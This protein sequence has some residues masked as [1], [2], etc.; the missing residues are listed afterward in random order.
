MR[1][2]QLKGIYEFAESKEDEWVFDESYILT[3]QN[4]NEI[5]E[6]NVSFFFPTAKKKVYNR[7]EI[8]VAPICIVKVHSIGDVLF[9]FWISHTSVKLTQVAWIQW[10]MKLKMTSL[11]MTSVCLNYTMWKRIW[12][13]Q[14]NRRDLWFTKNESDSLSIQCVCV[15]EMNTV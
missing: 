13:I 14:S 6:L 15:N 12:S 10:S 4:H 2:I 8:D 9:L 5:R 3:E 7:K 1:S 11:L